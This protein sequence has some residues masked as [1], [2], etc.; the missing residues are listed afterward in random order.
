MKRV[1]SE[2]EKI[3]LVRKVNQGTPLIEVCQKE[4]VSRSALYR[5]MKL[6][7]QRTRCNGKKTI[8]MRQVYQMER[9]L[10]ILE[11][12]VQIFRKSGCGINSS[13]DEKIAA[14]L[15]RRG[16]FTVFAICRTL[17]ILRSTFY[18]RKKVLTKHGLT[19]RMSCCA[20]RSKNTLMRAKS[21]SGQAK[22]QLSYARKVL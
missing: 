17:Q 2:D 6:Y 20:R 3:R 8:N 1:I 5:W 9:K 19:P 12:E 15:A 16:K 4:G 13:N 11:E 10:A 7:T 14:I 22:L 18:Q 21:T